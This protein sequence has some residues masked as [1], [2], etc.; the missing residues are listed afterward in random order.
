MKWLSSLKM[1]TTTR[2]QI[3]DGAL[4]ISRGANTVEIGINPTI[5][6]AVMGK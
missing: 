6:P 1:D 5:L 3:P 4:S 2:V